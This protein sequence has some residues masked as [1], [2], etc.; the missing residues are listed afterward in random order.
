MVMLH[1]KISKVLIALVI[2]GLLCALAALLI[3]LVSGAVSVITGILNTVIALIVI[4]A[5]VII[6]IWMFRYASKHK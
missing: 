4:A 6:V 3:K 5:L 1:M 2:F